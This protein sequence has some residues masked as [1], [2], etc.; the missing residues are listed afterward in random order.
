MTLKKNL[1]IRMILLAL[2]GG[3]TACGQK[4]FNKPTLQLTSSTADTVGFA[5]VEDKAAGKLNSS[6]VS[7]GV[8]K[9]TIYYFPIFNEDENLCGTKKNL[10]ATNG[11]VLAQV[12]SRTYEECAL[13]GSCAIVQKTKLRAF[14]IANRV[15]GQDHF[16][17]TTNTACKFG[18]GVKSSCLDP[19]YTVAADLKI[20]TPG[21]VIYI[22]NLR[23]LNLPNGSKHNGY[24]IVR[25]TGRA[26]VGEGRFDFF[27]GYFSWRDNENPFTKI[28]LGDKNTH[29]R[30]Y[31]ING[32]L[33][34]AVLENR[35]FPN[36]P[37]QSINTLP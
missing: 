15:N 7:S 25:D 33:A 21:D 28:G 26:I 10:L 17:E 37:N 2:L 12:C 22:P 13:Q 18:Y 32:P 27:S 19:F 29:L 11:A 8:I 4:G 16:F 36:L 30:F 35:D 9:P 1:K 3:L 23:G 31:K 6:V 5:M 34:K 14:N 24:F 20:Y